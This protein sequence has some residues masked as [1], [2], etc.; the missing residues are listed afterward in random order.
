[1]SEELKKLP[2]SDFVK[3]VWEDLSTIDLEG[4][5][6]VL[7]HA[8]NAT[9]LSWS[10]AWTLLMQRY[11]WSTEIYEVNELENKSVEVRC[12]LTVSDGSEEFTRSMHLPVMDAKMQAIFDPSARAISDTKARC[13]VKC[14]S[15]FGLGIHL[16][17][18]DEFPRLEKAPTVEPA[19]HITDEQAAN[20]FALSEEVGADH[21][22]FLSYFGIKSVEDLPASRL[23]EATKMLETKRKKQ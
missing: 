8:G 22:K 5:T 13:L 23:D 6:K 15:K 7:K 16:Y 17:A 11:P 14:L 10:N 21:K 18:G 12:T 9:Y 20:L 4:Y 2:Q 19:K 3:R 1:M